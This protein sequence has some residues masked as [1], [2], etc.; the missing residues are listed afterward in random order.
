MIGVGTNFHLCY[1]FEVFNYTEGR[2]KVV[3]SGRQ[4]KLMCC[5]EG[6]YHL[7]VSYGNNIIIMQRD[8]FLRRI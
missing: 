7:F 4:L 5:I 8:E 2:N 6:I 3:P 1:N